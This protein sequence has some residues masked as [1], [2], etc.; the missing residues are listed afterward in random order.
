MNDDSKTPTLSAAGLR[1]QEQARES[2]M[3]SARAARE[4]AE[5]AGAAANAAAANAAKKGAATSEF[6]ATMFAIGVSG[7][8]GALEVLSHV[9]GPWQVTAAVIV[10]AATAAG[11]YTNG[12]AKVKAAALQ[13]LPMAVDAQSG[14]VSLGTR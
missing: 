11:V 12:R 4:A 5:Q 9:P 10:G 13:A 6:K 3:R 1:S 8:M 7:L 2:T 14:S